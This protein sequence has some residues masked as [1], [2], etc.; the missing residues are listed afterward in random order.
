MV[1]MKRY[2]TRIE[3]ITEG[4]GDVK[5]VIYFH[6]SKDFND[7]LESFRRMRYPGYVWRYK[8]FGEKTRK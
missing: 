3:L 7:F 1:K 8:D 5:R 6:K 4:T 2:N